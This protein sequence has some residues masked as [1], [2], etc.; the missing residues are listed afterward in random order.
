MSATFA[1]FSRGTRKNTCRKCGRTVVVQEIDGA[2]VET[3]PELINVVPMKGPPV[4]VLAR[5]AHADLCQRYQIENEK[6]A[7]RDK[8]RAEQ[9]SA[10]KG[11]R[12]P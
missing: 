6:R 3:D 4:F 2:K 9:R 8:L 12:R 7:A 11:S 5:R 1:T 10:R